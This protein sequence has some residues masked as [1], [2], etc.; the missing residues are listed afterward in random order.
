MS[1]GH[2]AEPF[3]L[4]SGVRKLTLGTACGEQPERGL[5]KKCAAV[6]LA[7]VGDVP[8]EVDLEVAVTCLGLARPVG[9]AAHTW[10]ARVENQTGRGPGGGMAMAGLSLSAARAADS[11]RGGPELGSGQPRGLL[12]LPPCWPDPVPRLVSTL[13]RRS[14]NATATRLGKAELRA[15][16]EVRRNRCTLECTM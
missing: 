13:T 14:H 4:E 16:R 6:L 2:C 12:W 1:C 8:G 10:R 3:P 11:G 9:A 7:N 15:A 5:C